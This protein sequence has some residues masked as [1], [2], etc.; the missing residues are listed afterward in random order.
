MDYEHCRKIL[1]RYFSNITYIDD[2]FDTNLIDIREEIIP[3]DEVISDMPL[4]IQ[5]GEAFIEMEE[6]MDVEKII[7]WPEKSVQEQSAIT[8]MGMLQ[9]LGKEE[10]ADI[11]LIPVV[12]GKTVSDQFIIEKIKEANLAVID[13]DLGRGKKALPIIRDMLDQVAQLKVVVVYTKGYLEARKSVDEIFDKVEYIKNE[14]HIM[15]FQCTDKSKS[16]VFIVD[17]QY[18]NITNILDEVETIFI[19]R[20]GI[21]PIAVLDIADRLQEKSGNIFGAFCK[22]FED[23]YFMQMFYLEVDDGEISNYLSDFIIKKIYS[24]VHVSGELGQELLASKKNALIQIL[25]SSEM[26]KVIHNCID[27]LQSGIFGES[28]NLLELQKDI[29]VKVYKTIAHN[30]REDRGS[31]WKKI[32]QSF[33]PLLKILKAK[34]KEDKLNE[35]FG[36]KKEQIKKEFNEIY[37]KIDKEILKSIEIEFEN[38]KK[39]VMPLFLQTLIAQKDFLES[40]PGLV[41]NLKFHKYEDDDLES[42]LKDGIGLEKYEKSNFLMNKI[43]FGDILYDIETKY[44]LL[45]ITPPCDAFRPQKVDYNYTF[46][47]G[48]A[49]NSDQINKVLRENIHITVYPLKHQEEGDKKGVSYIKWRLFDIVTFNLE[50]DIEYKRICKYKRYYRLDE[51]YTRQIANKM[52]SHFSRAGVDEVFVKNEKDLVSVFT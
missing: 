12:Y 35:V 4:D 46:I 51:L 42:Y 47:K 11:N 14:D 17:K 33:K 40:L 29:N 3:E 44:Y 27:L 28:A 24:D 6:G 45:C 38:Y 34:R 41:E 5:A 15:C 10:F 43:H 37:E 16:L 8:L 48:N 30:L 7:T 50:D 25:E 39:E 23:A 49:V 36:D 13:W 52:L 21:M 2:Q 20:N 26:E 22:P 18:L 1:R 19:Q 31:S 32:I 9:K